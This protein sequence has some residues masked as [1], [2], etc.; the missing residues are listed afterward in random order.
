MLEGLRNRIFLVLPLIGFIIFFSFSYAYAVDN[1]CQ[2]NVIHIIQVANALRCLEDRLDTI[3]NTP[4]SDSTTASNLGS[5]SQVFSSEVGNDL[6]F[7]TLLGSSD[8][9]VT[10]QANTVTV[11]F[12]GTAGGDT[13]NCNNVGT[14]RLIH[15]VGSN[16]NA[17]SLIGSADINITNS[18][19]TITIDYNGTSSGCTDLN[20]LTDVTLTGLP[21]GFRQ[22]LQYNLTSD[23]WTNENGVFG[24]QGY[25]YQS[26]TKTNIG[27]AYIDVYVTAFDSEEMT[28]INCQGISFFTIGV[29]WDYVG[30][31]TQQ[32]RWVDANNNSNVLLESGTFTA[33]QKGIIGG[34]TT[35]SWCIDDSTFTIEMQGKST[36]AGDDPISRGYWIFAQ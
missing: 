14:G 6:Q 30:V 1:N 26:V 35:P 10:Q 31:G 12:N 22:Y 23:Q 11:D 21:N 19:N 24:Y 29:L 13:T 34:T 28:V 17:K 9:S 7:R 3:E 25:N 16:C 15:V 36:T 18:S 5:G 20:C 27:T 8:I 33:D 32:L 4:V 2:V